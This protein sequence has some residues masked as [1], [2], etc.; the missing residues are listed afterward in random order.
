MQFLSKA[1]VASNT[2]VL[3]ELGGSA[4]NEQ[5]EKQPEKNKSFFHKAWEN[6]LQSYL[7]LRDRRNSQL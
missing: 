4:V 3:A 2:F 1:G 6:T 7:H 5:E